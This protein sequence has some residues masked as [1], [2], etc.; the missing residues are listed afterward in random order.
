MIY[1]I[2]FTLSLLFLVIYDF[3]N[4]KI[5]SDFSYYLLLF[6]FIL[7]SGLRYKVGGD[8]LTYIDNFVFVPYLSDLNKLDFSMESYDPFWIILSSISKTLLDD[9]TLFQ[10]IHAILVN[11]V[12]FWFIYKYS[13][14]K[15][16]SAFI[17]LCASYLYFNMEIMRESLAIGVFLLAYP[18]F[19]AKKWMKFYILA[20][21][22]F[23]FHS[24]AIILFLFPLLS[25]VKFNVLTGVIS[26]GVLFFF[27][28]QQS[29]FDLLLL[30]D[31]ISNKFSTYKDISL[32]IFGITYVV[33]F[34]VLIPVFL[35]LINKIYNFK[36]NFKE[37]YFLYFLVILFSIFL[38][39]F[40]RFQNYFIPF[41]I[42]YFG[43]FLN[44]MMNLE[45]PVSI[46][47]I[48]VILLFLLVAVHK[49][50]Y[51]SNDTSKFAINTHQYNIFYP[52]SS[53]FEKN[54]FAPRQQIYLG[55]LGET[56]E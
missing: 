34:F 45:K 12:V 53:V 47:L 7:T 42:V 2:L 1:I 49:I 19:V 13:P 44:N 50:L 6:S 35:I 48:R 51:Y 9:F 55:G 27:I 28:S 22:A 26:V 16:T 3:N 25:R 36:T 31:R 24:S 33:C 52:Y 4:Q 29:F 38:P 11:S 23:L 54:E 18:S 37:L 46:K 40:Q 10:I 21:V 5:G 14:Y 17:Y 41:M 32:N 20:V 8:T 43:D 15:F 30:N 56:E 39:G